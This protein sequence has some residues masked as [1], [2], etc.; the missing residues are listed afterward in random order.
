MGNLYPCYLA[1]WRAPDLRRVPSH[2]TPVDG[3]TVA[4]RP[5]GCVLLGDV[6]VKIEISLCYDCRFIDDAGV[7]VVRADGEVFLVGTGHESGETEI[8]RD[9]IA[10]GW[11]MDSST[12][13][14]AIEWLQT[15]SACPECDGCG[16]VERVST[17]LGRS[18]S[19]DCGICDGCNGEGYQS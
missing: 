6:Q 4:A 13:L 9:G 2:A 14:E 11:T 7:E 10:N 5:W 15:G 17:G 18:W 16:R 19:L 1:A 3:W 8:F 12:T